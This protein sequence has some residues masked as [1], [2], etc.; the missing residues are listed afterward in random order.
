[1]ENRV[2]TCLVESARARGH[3]VWEP[4]HLCSMVVVHRGD[5]RMGDIVE[6]LDLIKTA[7]H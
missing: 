7:P 2:P 5:H 6:S 4:D 1:M 3:T